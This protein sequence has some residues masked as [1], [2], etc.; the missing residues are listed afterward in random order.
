ML[1]DFSLLSIMRP[2]FAVYCSA[3]EGTKSVLPKSPKDKKHAIYINMFLHCLNSKV[4]LKKGISKDC[5]K[6]AKIFENPC[7]MHTAYWHVW[8][9]IKV[10]KSLKIFSFSFKL[11]KET[12]SNFLIWWKTWWAVILYIYFDNGTRIKILSEIKSPL[13]DSTVHLTL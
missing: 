1:S 12:L 4:S 11:Q 8:S 3:E 7:V 10:A 13:I 2:I 5:F 9:T 6:S